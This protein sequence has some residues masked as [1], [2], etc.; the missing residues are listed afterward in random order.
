[1]KQKIELCHLENVSCLEGTETLRAF[2]SKLG[3][4]A[5]RSF[6]VHDNHTTWRNVLCAV[7]LEDPLS[8]S[9][10]PF[11]PLTAKSVGLS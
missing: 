6:P 3:E 7:A 9:H 10:P 8:L 4:K 1:M 2:F 11:M 5:F